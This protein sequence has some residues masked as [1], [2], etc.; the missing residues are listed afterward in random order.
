MYLSTS[1]EP[2]SRLNR[3]CFSFPPNELWEMFQRVLEAA[4][5]NVRKVRI[6]HVGLTCRLCPSSSPLQ[7]PQPGLH[8]HWPPRKGLMP[9]WENGT[10]YS[11]WIAF[12]PMVWTLNS[13]TSYNPPT[14]TSNT[15][16]PPTTNHLSTHISP[17]LPALWFLLNFKLIL[18]PVLGFYLSLFVRVNIMC[19]MVHVFNIIN[20]HLISSSFINI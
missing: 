4:A 5:G 8:Q 15:L 12:N 20:R 19:K 9:N 2:F 13:H 11:I 1:L 3:P 6:V 7:R 14:T 16:P 18:I 17:V 10:T